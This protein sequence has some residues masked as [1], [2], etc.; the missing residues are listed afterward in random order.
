M[1]ALI[2]VTT[3]PSL[4]SIDVYACGN[5][6]TVQRL[7]GSTYSAIVGREREV[8]VEGDNALNFMVGLMLRV[9]RLARSN[10]YTFIGEAD[11]SEQRVV[12]SPNILPSVRARITITPRRVKVSLGPS[13]VH[14]LRSRSTDHGAVLEWLS[15]ALTNM[16]ASQ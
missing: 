16:C 13:N 3:G 6:L 7:R 1:R 4:R 5:Y 14:K 12:Y 15:G 9:A 2:G 10:Y 11:V 8:Q